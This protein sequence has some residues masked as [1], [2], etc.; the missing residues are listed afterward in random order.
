MIAFLEELKKTHTDDESIRAFNE[1]ENSLLE[2][3]YG[4]VF[5][6][7]TEEVDERLLNEIPVLCEDKERRLCKDK[8]LPWN[9]II[10]GD[11]L[12][13][14]YL[15]E[16]THKG[17]IDCIYIDP[18]YNTGAKDWKYNNN[19][20]DSNDVYRHSK[21]LSMMKSRLLIAK[22][23]LNPENSV[24]ICTIDEKEYLRLG[25]LLEELFPNAKIQMVTDV[26][27]QK[28]VA[29]DNE[30]SRVDEYI[31]FVKIGAAS[32]M[33]CINNMLH[34]NN[35][36]K[37]GTI[38]I[39]LQRSG[40]ESM[41]TDRPNMCFPIF[42]DEKTE[43]IVDVGYAPDL[44][45]PIS[46]IKFDNNLT[47]VWPQTIG[48]EGRWQLGRDT[49]LKGLRDGTIKLGGKNRHESWSIMYLNE[50]AKKEIQDGSLIIKG[51]D[52]NGA[53]IVERVA[54]K[55]T[56]A[57]TV[58]NQISHDASVNGSSLLL[59]LFNDKLFAFPKSIYSTHDALMFFVKEKKDAIILDFFA[60]S[61]TTLHA[62][63][64]LNAEDGGHRQCIM[65][66]N[67]E[68]SADEE[69]RLTQ[70]GYKKGDD[71]WEK[72]G[73]AKYVTWP[74]TVCSIE[75]KDIK[76]NPLKG[77]YGVEDEIYVIDEDSIVVSKSSGKPIKRNLYKK[78]KIQTMP[79]LA[80]IKKAD[81]FKCNV[82][83]FKC[84]WI[85][86]RPED[87]LLSNA[88]CLHIKEMIELQ[89]GREVD[90][91]KQ[92]LI[93]NKDDYNKV[94]LNPDVYEKIETIWLN[95][96]M[97]LSPEE[98]ELLKAKGFKYIPREFFGH[99]LREAAE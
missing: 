78:T 67:N 23:L 61:G 35:E 90:G 7:H 52:E 4:L 2:K 20:V 27:N 15:L 87:Y 19:Y 92:V 31:Y 46:N 74:R 12:Q 71:E 54:D 64:L 97:I 95:Q 85:P 47:A 79:E 77:D 69:K 41:R 88:L 89:T 11:N 48:K 83:Y 17:R 81:G 80:K 56:P 91:V 59:K 84:D 30:F 51:K 22:H 70:Q 6:E 99:E 96:N 13:A 38:W 26:I 16:K 75:G 34:K 63:N 10:E 82:K 32:P 28:G 94:V 9:F 3:K 60:G 44:S 73:I 76:G 36:Q 33:L 68:V 42:V 58:W 98:L 66:T 62:I 40:S 25:C 21:W 1:I 43:K 49:V 53:L 8:N 93:L 50:G 39:P 24:L 86:R 55:V 5:E 29:R 57:K 72:L 14:L 45:I 18:P 65:V 37:K